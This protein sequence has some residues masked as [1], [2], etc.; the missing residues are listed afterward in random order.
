MLGQCE[1]MFRNPSRAL[2]CFSYPILTKVEGCASL[3]Q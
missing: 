2:Y 1:V 3:L